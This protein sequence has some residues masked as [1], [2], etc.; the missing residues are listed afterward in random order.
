MGKIIRGGSALLPLDISTYPPE[1]N[2][3]H[4]DPVT[5]KVTVGADITGTVL[6]DKLTVRLRIGEGGSAWTANRGAL[7]SG[8]TGG[9]SPGQG[10]GWTPE[11][12]Y[13]DGEWQVFVFD[14]TTQARFDGT[15]KL[16]LNIFN[17]EL[18]DA[19]GWAELQ[20]V[21]QTSTGGPTSAKTTNAQVQKAPDTFVFHSFHPEHIMVGNG[22]RAKLEWQGTQDAA[23][24]MFWD[25]NE[26]QLQFGPSKPFGEWLS[27]ALHE[28]TGFMLQARYTKDG[29]T[30]ERTLTTS[31]GVVDPDL[32][33]TNLTVLGALTAD[34][35]VTTTGTLTSKGALTAKSGLTASG[36]VTAFGGITATD[37]IVRIR[38]LRG[39]YGEHLTIDSPTDFL[40]GDD[41]TVAASLTTNGSFYPTG[42]MT[43]TGDIVRIKD[44]R[45]P[46]GQWLKIN[47]STEFLP[48]NDV[49][50]NGGLETKGTLTTNG[51]TDLA[52]RPQQ[53]G[54]TWNTTRGWTAPTT[55][56][57][58]AEVRCGGGDRNPMVTITSDGQSVDASTFK[59]ND[60]VRPGYSVAVLAIRKGAD[61]SVWFGDAGGD[62]GPDWKAAWFTWVPFGV[63]ALDM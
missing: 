50:V 29:K 57:A 61:F 9:E 39:P 24:T 48:D 53:C 31:V 37:G 33:V 42:G 25:K 13:D 21:E 62:G 17:I 58:I 38:D 63:G 45:G 40:A 59:F 27:P 11:D 18:N 3:G 34:G 32:T 22:D 54:L 51:A 26:E 1:L 6:C 35:E 55:G 4:P 36:G 52:S 46:Y 19:P 5:L 23:Y 47:S 15:W 49:L 12:G 28:P 14:P 16:T 30:F 41:V 56:L 60:P 10:D 20:V 8:V 44:L 43:A 2:I 7:K